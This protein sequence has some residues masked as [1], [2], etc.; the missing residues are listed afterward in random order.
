MTRIDPKL[1]AAYR[2]TLYRVFIPG[3]SPIDLR[4][5]AASAALDALLARHGVQA[6]A[7]ITAWNPG[8]KPVAATENAARH[9]QLLNATETGGWRVFFDLLPDNK[10]ADLRCVLRLRGRPLTE[11]W[12]YLWS[13]G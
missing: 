2:A 10:R 1:D 5:D 13:P 11:T 8:S 6:W 9:A 12:V 4:V 3:G 7:F